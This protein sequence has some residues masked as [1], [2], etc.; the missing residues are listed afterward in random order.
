MVRLADLDLDRIHLLAPGPEREEVTAFVHEM[1]LRSLAWFIRARFFHERRRLIWRPYLDLLCETMEAVAKRD[2]RRLMVNMPPRSLKSETI[3]QSWQAWM[4]ARDDTARSSVV[5]ASYAASLAMRDSYK[6]RDIMRSEWFQ[7]IA[8][9]PV[10]FKLDT[11]AAWETQGGVARSAAG[12]GGPVTGKGGDHLLCDDLLKP[13]DSDSEVMRAKINEWFGGTFRSRLNNPA[14]GTITITAQRVHEDDPCGM[15]L[16]KMINKDADQWMHLNLPLIAEKRQSYSFGNGQTWVREPGDC[17]NP[18]RWPKTE[19]AALRAMLGPNFDGQYQQRPVKQQGGMLQPAKLMRSAATPQELIK[20]WGLSVHLYIDLATKAKQSIKDDPDWT[21]IAALARDQ[22]DRLWILDLWRDR[23]AM[24]ASAAAMLDM[25]KRWNTNL[26][27]GE[28]IGLQ[29]SFQSVLTL[30]CRIR[31]L[32]RPFLRDISIQGA[33]D[34]VQK[35]GSFAG[36]L[37]I[38]MVGVPGGAPW[39]PALESEMRTFPLGAHD[40]QVDA[41]SLGIA[42]Q[43]RIPKGEAAPSHARLEKGQI[44]GNLLAIARRRQEQLLKGEQGPED[45]WD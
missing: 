1:A 38:G 33:G 43:Q 18:V 11:Q 17:L 16:G 19:V 29:H 5:S 28:R 45:T 24:D 31:R 10:A 20:R 2:V 4:V 21:V 9:T 41:I 15:L 40:D 22:M 44:D 25:M 39:L 23:V 8:K 13:Q 12:S 6:T 7:L 30:T 26:V 36:L 32:P 37:N 35:A 27:A 42:D 3:T 34:K 14:D